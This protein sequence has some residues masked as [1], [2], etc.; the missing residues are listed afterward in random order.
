M[1]GSENLARRQFGYIDFHAAIAGAAVRIG[2]RGDR[3]A[4]TAAFGDDAGR[5]YAAHGQVVARMG[6]AFHRQG[7][8]DGVAARVV[9]VAD[10]ADGGVR[11]VVQG[12]SE[13]VEDGAEVALD[14]GPVGIE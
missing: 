8:V 3:F 12:G 10:D 9:R 2:V 5:R 7:L 11:I 6:G 14:I 1:G 13:A 4:R